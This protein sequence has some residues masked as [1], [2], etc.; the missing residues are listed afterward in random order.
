MFS[1]WTP[2]A[3]Q[4]HTQTHMHRQAGVETYCCNKLL[5]WLL[6][7]WRQPP[8][9]PPTAP[10]CSPAKGDTKVTKTSAEITRAGAAASRLTVHHLSNFT[11]T[12][13]NPASAFLFFFRLF[14]LTADADGKS[15]TDHDADGEGEGVAVKLSVFKSPRRS[16]KVQSDS[17]DEQPGKHAPTTKTPVIVW[18]KLLPPSVDAGFSHFPLHSWEESDTRQRWLPQVCSLHNFPRAH[19]LLLLRKWLFLQG[20]SSFTQQRRQKQCS[21]VLPPSHLTC[22]FFPSYFHLVKQPQ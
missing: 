17:L 19:K 13:L 12:G 10:C 11:L 5:G 7:W 4:T 22:F 1:H 6:T 16:M 8:L 2:R 14:P 9:S 18:H 20:R 3:A 21:I 15:I